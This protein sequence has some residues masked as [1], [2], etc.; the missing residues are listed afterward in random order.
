MGPRSTFNF[1]WSTHGDDDDDGPHFEPV[2]P[3]PDKI[4]VKTGE[5]DEEEFFCNRAKL[6]RFDTESKEWKERGIGN[7]KILRHKTSGKIRLLMRREQVLK[8]CANH[9]ISPDMKLTPNAGSDKSFV[10]HALDYADESPKPEQLAIRF[11][12]PEEAGLFKCKFEEA[13]NIL[14]ASGAK[15]ATPPNQAMRMVKEPTITEYK[16]YLGDFNNW[17]IFISCLR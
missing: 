16:S 1:G 2:V 17:A 14:K 15:I 10:W 8:I 7:V 3:L 11:K 9:Y 6:Y 5:E 12:T 4:E 13:Q